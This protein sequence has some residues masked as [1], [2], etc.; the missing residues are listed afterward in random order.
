MV[1]ILIIHRLNVNAKGTKVMAIYITCEQRDHD[2]GAEVG[3]AFDPK[4]YFP[5]GLTMFT[6]VEG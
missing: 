6:Q 3:L 2:G 1:R 4:R 5:R